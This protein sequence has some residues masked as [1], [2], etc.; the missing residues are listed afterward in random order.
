MAD[1][2]LW[3]H[4]IKIWQ[5]HGTQDRSTVIRLNYFFCIVLLQ[6]K[7]KVC[8]TYYKRIMLIYFSTNA[9]FRKAI[10]CKINRVFY[11]HVDT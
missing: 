2:S 8:I 9:L 11:Y 5:C 3:R 10:K 4:L 7:T 6:Q 1:V